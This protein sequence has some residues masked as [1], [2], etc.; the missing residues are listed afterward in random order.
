QAYEQYVAF[1]D[2]REAAEVNIRAQF[3]RYQS[4]QAIFL[5]VLQAITDWGNAVSNEANFLSQYNIQ[6]A[7]LERQTG[8][9]MET[10]GV[11]FYEERYG[12]VGP[13]GYWHDFPCYPRDQAPTPND[14]R[15]PIS[16]DP[17][18][19]SFNLQ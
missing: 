17:A 5:N 18:E 11:S 4:N 13:L 8:T 10:H 1:H 12:S 16:D 14:D 7:T 9:I 15:Y 6:L 3:A 2:A 19:R